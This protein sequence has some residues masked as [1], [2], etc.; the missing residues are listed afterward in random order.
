MNCSKYSPCNET[1]FKI[2]N[3]ICDFNEKYKNSPPVG[4]T[5]SKIMLS[6]SSVYYS[7]AKLQKFGYIDWIYIE[8]LP[9]RFIVP[10]WKK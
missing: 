10:L 9:T 2:L 5:A 6:V 3:Q 1:D 4:F 8:H 7:L